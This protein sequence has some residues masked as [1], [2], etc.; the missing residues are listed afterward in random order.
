[1]PQ[2]VPTVTSDVEVVGGLPHV[3]EATPFASAG[4]RSCSLSDPPPPPPLRPLIFVIQ[5]RWRRSDFQTSDVG[6]SALL[7]AADQMTGKKNSTQFSMCIVNANKREEEED[8][9]VGPGRCRRSS[10]CRD[11][12]N[13][14][15]ASRSHCRRI[16]P[17]RE[18][19]SSCWNS[20]CSSGKDM[21][22][23]RSGKV[24]SP[25]VSSIEIRPAESPSVRPPSPSSSPHF[26]LPLTYL[27]LISLPPGS[28]LSCSPA[29]QY[30]GNK[31]RAQF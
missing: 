17:W 18:A 24:I 4:W 29:L 15:G 5:S 28:Y 12:Q 30:S 16:N 1:M 9:N 19:S 25:L 10:A 6:T 8:G 13:H 23:E 20:C 21:S 7:D 14:S 22:E 11:C 31:K 2:M 26:L 3:F 27:I